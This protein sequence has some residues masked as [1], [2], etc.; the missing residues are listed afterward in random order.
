MVEKAE[1]F[2]HISLEAVQSTKVCMRDSSSSLHLSQR[3][4]GAQYL[5]YKT[6]FVA[7][8]PLQS[9]YKK[10]QSFGGPAR[11]PTIRHN[12]EASAASAFDITS[13]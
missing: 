11:F 9:L 8:A 12:L 6:N 4:E 1:C 13:S 5:L 3:G 7:N 10:C 2:S